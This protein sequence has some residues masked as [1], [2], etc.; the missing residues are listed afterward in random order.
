M[1][2]KVIELDAVEAMYKTICENKNNIVLICL[3]PYTNVGTLIQ[4]HPDVV[5]M[6][7]HIYCEGCAAYNHKIEGKKW[8]D[9]V[10]FNASTDPEAMEIV[11]NSGI[12]ITIIPS[13]M[14]RELANFNEQE[15]YK[16]REI[17][18]V[19][20]FFYEMYSAYWEHNYTDRRIATNDTCAIMAL[21]FPK[22][23]KKKKAIMEMDTDE[24]PGKTTVKY[25]KH[26]NVNFV[27][28]VKKKAMHK[29][30][31]EA[32]AKMGIFK[33]YED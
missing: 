30:F 15:V 18:D 2:T 8:K 32:I 22:L 3:G 9:Y 6:V 7:N 25:S 5:E 17:N 10:S 33:F 19:G 20:R 4:K 23:F 31:Y 27:Y 28:G 12:P 13:R 11:F 14:G 29:I 26:G 21:R 24:Q 1:N 16:I